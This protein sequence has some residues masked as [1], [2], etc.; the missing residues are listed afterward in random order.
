[1][2]SAASALANFH[3]LDTM[4]GGY[5]LA[6]SSTAPSRETGQDSQQAGEP[7]ASRYNPGINKPATANLCSAR[8]NPFLADYNTGPAEVGIFIYFSRSTTVP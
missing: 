8:C 3:L 7:T 5:T 4:L 6:G 2:T 1:M